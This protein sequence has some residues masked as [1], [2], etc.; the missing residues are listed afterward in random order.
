MLTIGAGAL[1]VESNG[2]GISPY[3]GVEETRWVAALD[4]GGGVLA[5]FGAYFSATFELHALLALPHPTVRF[6]GVDRATIGFPAIL[7]SLTMVAWL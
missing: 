6:D 3:Q 7:A 1:R 2:E 4:A 5:T